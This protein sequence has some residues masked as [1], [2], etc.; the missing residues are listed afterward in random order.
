[1]VNKQ[2]FKLLFLFY[3]FP[4]Y[5]FAQNEYKLEVIAESEY[6]WTGITISKENRIFVCFPTW[7][8]KSPYKVAEIKNGKTTPYPDIES[9]NNIFTCIQSVIVDKENTLWILDSANP[10]FKGVNN[11][12]AKLFRVNLQNNKIIKTYTFPNNVAPKD[13]YLNDLRIDNERG[14]IY[15]TDSQ[16]G[17]IVVL[18]ILTGKS[19]RALDNSIPEVKANLPYIN[20]RSTGKWGNIVNSDGIELINDGNT[21][22]FTALTGNI[23]YK[24]PTRVLRDTSL[25]IMDRRKYIIKEYEEN[26]P[27]DGLILLNDKILMAN[28][29]H[30]S[31]WEYNLNKRKGRNIVLKERIRW[32]DS[33]TADKSGNI[34]FTTSQINYKAE[35]LEHFKIYKMYK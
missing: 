12:G 2:H 14:F 25:S 31:I 32:A 22:I 9:N 6:Q 30:E 21:L 1:M 3:L 35:E 10:K 17:G 5:A 23:L 19:W 27:S 29:P 11:G 13:S 33:F 16:L 28:L 20:F 7:D 34:Y 26:V 15:I 8:I 4:L 24:I 18:N